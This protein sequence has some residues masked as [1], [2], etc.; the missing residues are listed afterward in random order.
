MMGLGLKVVCAC[1]LYAC[2]A[3]VNYT[4]EGAASLFHGAMQDVGVD[5]AV[6]STTSYIPFANLEQ[7][8]SR[9]RAKLV[10]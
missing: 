6:E 10:A 3:V 9:N 4:M 2:Y 7:R 8:R 5:D 1:F